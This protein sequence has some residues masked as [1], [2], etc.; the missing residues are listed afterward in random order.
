MDKLR[1]LQYFVAAAEEGSF[2]GAARRLDVSVPAVLKLVTALE[3][4]LRA[5]LFDRSSKGLA[6]TAEGARYFERCRPLLDELLEVDQSIGSAAASARG[7]VV[8][9]APAFVPQACLAH[10]LPVFHARFPDI[11]LDF[12]IFDGMTDADAAAVDVFVLFGWHEAPDLIQKPIGQSRY[13]VLA[14]P[15]YWAAN[16]VPRR[17]RDLEHHQCFVV[18]G[19]SGILLDHW[20]FSRGGELESVTVG[21]WLAGTPRDIILTFALAGEGVVRV[22]DFLTNAHERLGRLVPVLE[23]WD[24]LH[25]PPANVLYRAKHRRTPR[26]RVFVELVAEAFRKLE[27]DREAGTVP[28]TPRPGYLSKHY[29]RTSKAARVRR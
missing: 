22:N 16:G 25:A 1:A 20:E 17:P 8:I 13:R 4:E 23:D 11:E 26:V 21:G 14:A 24:A 6:L 19:A 10:A 2:S 5:P 27:I 15:S 3:H 29:S 9:G 28:S 12:R 7:V 18:R